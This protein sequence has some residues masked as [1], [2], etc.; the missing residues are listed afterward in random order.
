MLSAYLRANHKN[1]IDLANQVISVIWKPQIH[2][3][4]CSWKLWMDLS[5]FK[6][7]MLQWGQLLLLEKV[8][9]SRNLWQRRKIFHSSDCRDR[10]TYGNAKG[11]HVEHKASKPSCINLL[12]PYC[13]L[14]FRKFLF[15]D[16]FK[17]EW[18]ADL[19]DMPA[20]IQAFNTNDFPVPNRHCLQHSEQ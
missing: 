20:S 15:Q 11:I 12:Y 9:K 8:S 13:P 18:M 3:C 10:V 17:E 6:L 5:K 1:I 14:L 19:Q 2:K 4:F 7:W 16:E